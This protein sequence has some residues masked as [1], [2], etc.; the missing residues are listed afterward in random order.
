MDVIRKSWVVCYPGRLLQRL[1]AKL[2]YTKREIQLLSREHFGNIFDTVKQAKEAVK[3]AET[4][5]DTNPSQQHWLALQEGHA[6]MRNSLI[7][8]EAYWKQNL[9][10]NSSRMG[11]KIQSSFM[12]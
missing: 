12:L 8:E 6:V 9:E 11:T 2:W 1:A 5:L 3:V 10:S 4:E 7:K